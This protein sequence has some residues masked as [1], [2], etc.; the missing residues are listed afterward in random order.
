M[1]ALRQQLKVNRP[2]LTNSSLTTYLSILRGMTK[3]LQCSEQQLLECLQQHDKVL[4]V[5]ENDEIPV[6]KTKLAVLISLLKE[7]NAVDAYRKQMMEDAQAH[8]DIL[9]TQT[10]TPKQAE[11]WMEWKDV[12]KVH[13]QLMKLTSPLFKKQKL[14]KIEFMNVLKLVLLSLYVLVPPRRSKDFIVMKTKDYD[15]LTDNYFDGKKFVFN[16]FKTVKQQGRQEVV[17]P[18]KL[19]LLLKKWLRL[20]QNETDLLLVDHRFRPLTPSRITGLMNEIFDDK[21]ISTSMLRHFFIS[22]KFE[23]MPSLKQMEDLGDQM[24][25]SVGTQ[26]GIYRKL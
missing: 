14:N 7:G 15:P 17:V 1:E 10:K 22:S 5:L 26:Q 4:K 23:G 20:I 25:H 16:V 2:H 11:N 21:K 19:K 12:V 18:S 8:A 6:R 9:K 13:D 3:K 24:G